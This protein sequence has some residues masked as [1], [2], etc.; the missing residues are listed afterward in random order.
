[1]DNELG[2]TYVS[3]DRHHLQTLE[4]FQSTRQPDGYTVPDNGGSLPEGHPERN[5]RTARTILSAV[6]GL[7]VVAGLAWA[8]ADGPREASPAPAQQSGYEQSYQ[9]GR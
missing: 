5:G 2:Q 4:D 9:S 1:M 8:N 7:A 3:Y 6:A